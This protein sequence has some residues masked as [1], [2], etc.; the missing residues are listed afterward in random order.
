AAHGVHRDISPVVDAHGLLQEIARRSRQKPAQARKAIS[1]LE[2]RLG[3]A[4]VA[5]DT[6]AG[7]EADDLS[8]PVDPVRVRVGGGVVLGIEVC[9]SPVFVAEGMS[10]EC[11]RIR[12]ADYPAPGADGMGFTV[13]SSQRAQI[14]QLTLFP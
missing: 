1:I 11:G 14:T 4:V 9:H 3:G 12:I 13:Y 2:K 10:C 8:S 5:V 6:E 7:A